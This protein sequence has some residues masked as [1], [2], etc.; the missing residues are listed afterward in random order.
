MD[1]SNGGNS[2][3]E[4]ENC[5]TLKCPL[6]EFPSGAAKIDHGRAVGSVSSGAS[7]SENIL[8]LSVLIVPNFVGEKLSFTASSGR[9][10]YEF[11]SLHGISPSS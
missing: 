4:M 3:F 7:Q 10:M 11:N 2:R 9:T 6:Q 5:E 1:N 8:V